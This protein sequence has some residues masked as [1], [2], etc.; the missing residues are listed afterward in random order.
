MERQQ[1]DL[2][3]DEPRK[4]AR[5]TDPATNHLA[6]A[7]LKRAAAHRAKIL[8]TLDQI[9]SGTFEEIAERAGMRDSQVWRR[10]S[11][12]HRVGQAEPTG[13]DRMGKSGRFQRVW[14]RTAAR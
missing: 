1:L 6:A 2:F 3:E 12:L 11:D 5:R 7:T 14:R 8:Q 9:G 10:L 13:E 4:L